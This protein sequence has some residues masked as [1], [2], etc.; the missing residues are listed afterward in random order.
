M[1]E[2]KGKIEKM[3]KDRKG[4]M[5]DDV[6]YSGYKASFLGDAQVGDTVEF[7][8]TSKGDFKNI[9][10]GTLKVLEKSEGKSSSGGGGGGG[11]NKGGGGYSKG[12]FRS[13]PQLVRTDAVNQALKLLEQQNAQYPS[14]KQAIK[15]TLYVANVIAAY[16]NAEINA[17][18]IEL[19]TAR[20]DAPTAAEPAKSQVKHETR[21]S[22]EPEPPAAAEP[23][24]EQPAS[25][26]PSLDAF[27]DD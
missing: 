21:K 7:E 26:A 2:M 1:S 4:L 13:V 25:P 14:V 19:P 17:D 5:I 6:W 8:F 22:P 16:V 20:L 27:L 12:E 10:D 11:G 9:T 15:A 24:P 23:E 3:R 18:G